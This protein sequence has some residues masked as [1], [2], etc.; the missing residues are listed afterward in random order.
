MV[1]P[2]DRYRRGFTLLEM[3]LVIVLI[4]ITGTLV[5]GRWSPERDPFAQPATTLMVTL[6]NALE[7][8]TQ[9]ETL[10]GLALAHEGWQLMS[11]SR[12]A[13]S[14]QPH[15]HISQ[16]SPSLLPEAM[17]V[18]LQIEQHAVPLAQQL[19]PNAEPQIWLFPG[20]ET[21][22]FT[23]SLLK[24]DCRQRITANGFMSFKREE[25]LCNGE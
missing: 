13:P 4:G 22:V 23:L 15:W 9:Q 10:Y 18:S 2:T 7:Q 17:L 6:Q 12:E 1:Q 16:Q 20:G 8:A 19:T 11:Y 3:M 21:T 14:Q 24:D 5:M 25:V